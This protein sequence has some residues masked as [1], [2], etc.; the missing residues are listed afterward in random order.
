MCVY[1]QPRESFKYTVTIAV[2][3]YISVASLYN[4]FYKRIKQTKCYISKL[5]IKKHCAKILMSS[6]INQ[7]KNAYQLEYIKLA[8]KY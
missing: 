3:Y 4:K 1:L 6:I 5:Y 2:P 8:I 7:V